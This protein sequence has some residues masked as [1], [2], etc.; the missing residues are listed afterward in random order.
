M[1]NMHNGI[2]MLDTKLMVW[3][4]MA[5]HGEEQRMLARLAQA[6]RRAAASRRSPCMV[7]PRLVSEGTLATGC[8]FIQSAFLELVCAYKRA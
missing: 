6:S 8:Q 1:P 3:R 4:A 7:L 2:A 5:M